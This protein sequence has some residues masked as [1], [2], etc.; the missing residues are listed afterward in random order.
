MLAL[1]LTFGCSSRRLMDSGVRPRSTTGAESSLLRGRE[2]DRFS[3][4]PRSASANTAALLGDGSPLN[5]AIREECACVRGS[6]VGYSYVIFRGVS[7]VGW[8]SWITVL[9]RSSR[10]SAR[11]WQTFANSGSN[12]SSAFLISVSISDPS[13][14]TREQVVLK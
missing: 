14:S 1:L 3:N 12:A 10:R 6:S 4:N 2:G 13:S 11:G 8:Y 9:D 5:L 7:P